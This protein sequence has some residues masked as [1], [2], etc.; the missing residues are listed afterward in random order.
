MARGE[1]ARSGV[2]GAI[3]LVAFALLLVGFVAFRI[4][5]IHAVPLT[6]AWRWFHWAAAVGADYLIPDG[7]ASAFG[8]DRLVWGGLFPDGTSM[9]S[10]AAYLGSDDF[11]A[12]PVDKAQFE[13]RFWGVHAPLVA[14]PALYWVRR[15]WTR[16][17]SAVRQ[18]AMTLIDGQAP[19][20]PHLGEFV[21]RKLEEEPLSL[22]N[23][24]G[25]QNPEAAALTAKEFAALSPPP[26]VGF[27]EDPS[28]Q[29]PIFD[30]LRGREMAFDGAQAT[31][32]FKRQ[33]GGLWLGTPDCLSATERTVYDRLMVRLK[34]GE[35]EVATLL[36]GF[37][38]R[39]SEAPWG[40]GP[41]ADYCR[42]TQEP[43]PSP[44]EALWAQVAVRA[45]A[46]L[47][48][49]MDERG[50]A[51]LAERV[52][53]EKGNAGLVRAH[54]AE[55]ACLKHAFIRPALMTLL[56][57]A[58]SGQVVSMHEFRR[59]LKAKDRPLW[60]ALHCVGR[61][62]AFPEAAGAFAHWQIERLIESP[63]PE[64]EVSAAVT[65]LRESLGIESEKKNG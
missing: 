40:F 8:Y 57:E 19:F 21:G 1:D 24:D 58:R 34:G 50:F 52:A 44:V 29:V 45:C 10:V 60:Y 39:L 42:L 25:T 63:V 12:R 6:N 43:P 59:H 31:L 30:P 20:R 53:F 9:G 51:G 56:E 11:W 54:Y 64:P 13:R 26:G 46:E 14:L 4:A 33:L 18:N 35:V 48:G 49:P 32:V 62:V 38:A 23:A 47:E 3:V 55:Q 41:D 36:R 15:I 16:S 37:F 61:R 17:D 5:D 27:D 22:R 7:L 2:G 65:G 28:M